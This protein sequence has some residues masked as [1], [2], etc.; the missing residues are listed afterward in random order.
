MS[1]QKCK[2]YDKNII[3]SEPTKKAKHI[4]SLL[5]MVVK[6]SGVQDYYIQ[7]LCNMCSCYIIQ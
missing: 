7:S 5:D 4:T 3:I 1:N 2:V 6:K